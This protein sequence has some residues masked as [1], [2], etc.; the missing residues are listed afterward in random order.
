MNTRTH[1][2]YRRSILLYMGYSDLSGWATYHHTHSIHV[3]IALLN[4]PVALNDFVRRYPPV[5]RARRCEE[6]KAEVRLWLKEIIDR[7]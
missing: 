2:R 6:V 1:N 4:Q 7:H 3:L 5:Q